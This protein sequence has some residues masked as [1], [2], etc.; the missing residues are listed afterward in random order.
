MAVPVISSV[1]PDHCHPG[2]RE[3]LTINGANFDLPPAPPSTGYVGGVPAATV[4]VTVD[5]K[6]AED[7]SVWSSSL[8]TCTIPPFRGEPSD[9]SASPGYDATV[10]V[11]NIAT[12]EMAS[13]SG[14]LYYRRA[15]LARTNGALEWILRSIL[16][17][18]RRHV[19]DNVVFSSAIDFDAS[20]GDSLDIVELAE[21]PGVALFGPELSEDKEWRYNRND[22]SNPSSTE[23]EKRGIP[24]F[25]VASFDV[26]LVGKA[27]TE[28]AALEQ[29][30]VAMFARTPRV[31][32][33]LTPG[34]SSTRDEFDWYLSKLPTRAGTV[35]KGEVYSASASFEVRG[36]PIDQDSGRLVEYGFVVGDSDIELETQTD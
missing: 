9:L 22:L 10:T 5:G 30:F 24:L 23:Y 13:V 16:R 14:V 6:I 8:L 21:V 2:G 34:D 17:V 7:V 33:E 36:I 12:G 25:V 32:I 29:E 27:I 3:I 11:E 28:L 20:V 18:I 15:S 4:R 19:L 1:S 26:T 31:E 35:G